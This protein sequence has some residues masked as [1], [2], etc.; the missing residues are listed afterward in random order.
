MHA[1]S[2]M[3]GW[4]FASSL[5]VLSIDCLAMQVL[6]REVHGLYDA[7]RR[8]RVVWDDVPGEVNRRRRGLAKLQRLI[9]RE[10]VEELGNAC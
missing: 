8:A 2:T 9:P 5:L 10:A 4:G 7:E 3:G 1:A 6:R